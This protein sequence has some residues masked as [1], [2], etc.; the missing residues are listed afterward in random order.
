MKM[1]DRREYKM[2]VLG[3]HQGNKSD[4]GW[5]MGCMEGRM[6][7]LF[8]GMGCKEFI[9]GVISNGVHRDIKGV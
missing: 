8:K 3:T 6:G 5:V 7:M 9:W 1:K 4:E 2:N